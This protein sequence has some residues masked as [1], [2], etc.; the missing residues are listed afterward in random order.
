MHK[1][2]KQFRIGV[3]KAA[4]NHIS[5][6]SYPE[7]RLIFLTIAPPDQRYALHETNPSN[8]RIQEQ[9]HE[10]KKRLIYMK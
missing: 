3:L 4:R 6:H 1:E 10:V 9:S 2:K 7:I 5:V 8:I